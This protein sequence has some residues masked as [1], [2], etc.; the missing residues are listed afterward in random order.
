MNRS[1]LLEQA[2]K[3]VNG[4]REDEY[5]SPERN[6]QTIAQLWGAYINAAC[7]NGKDYD[8]CIT[9]EDVAALMIL[10]KVARISSD[11]QHLDS[12]IDV[13]GYGACGGEIATGGSAEEMPAELK[14]ACFSVEIDPLALI[15]A[16]VKKAD[17]IKP[18][19]SEN[20]D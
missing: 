14:E 7:I 2:E 6:F 10:M 16:L 3:I 12:W 9:E 1:E 17:E 11:K 8:F 18:G 20:D 19:G 15:N 13:I 5:G 4:H